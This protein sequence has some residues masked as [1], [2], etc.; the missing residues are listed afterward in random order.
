MSTT[1]PKKRQTPKSLRKYLIK[2]AQEIKPIFWDV[3]N[4]NE[5][6]AEAL[7]ER[8]INY[9]T[10]KEWRKIY[11]YPD[12][13]AL[14]SVYVRIASKKRLNLRPQ[15]KVFWDKLLMNDE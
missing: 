6:S 13:D 7:L 14:K 4:I 3:K 9:G 12:K 1:S 10:I 11:R 2:I 8:L 15:F 5:L